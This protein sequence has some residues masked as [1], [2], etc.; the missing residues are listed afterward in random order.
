MILSPSPREVQFTGE[1][2]SL[3]EDAARSGVTAK[4]GEEFAHGKINFQMAPTIPIIS[5]Q[6]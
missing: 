3:L 2:E 6:R 5:K 4:C 1:I